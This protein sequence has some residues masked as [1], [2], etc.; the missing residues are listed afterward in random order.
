MEQRASWRDP[1]SGAFG[2]PSDAATVFRVRDGLLHRIARS[3]D[4]ATALA[5]AG[6]DTSDEEAGDAASPP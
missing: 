1:A 3:A 6:Q 4:L 5:A 2:E